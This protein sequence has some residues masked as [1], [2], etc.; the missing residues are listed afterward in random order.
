MAVVEPFTSWKQAG[1]KVIF[2]PL[3]PLLTWQSNN[4]RWKCSTMRTATVRDLRNRYTSLLAWINAGEEIVITQ[5]GKIIA[6]LIPEKDQS[7]QVVDWSQSAAIK[8]DRSGSSIMT[9]EESLE[10][11]HD[12]SGKWWLLPT[13]AFCFLFTGTMYTHLVLLVFWKS[14]KHL[15]SWPAWVN[16]SYQMLCALR[17]FDKP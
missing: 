8:R 3:L 1:W 12:A 5:R 6:R 10:I 14:G 11:I 15:W 16:M 17:N 4:V 9:A 7:S 2:L 13:Q